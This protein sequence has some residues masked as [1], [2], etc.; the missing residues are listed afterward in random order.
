MRLDYFD[1]SFGAPRGV[2]ANTIDAPD[3]TRSVFVGGTF[4]ATRIRRFDEVQG[5]N[6]LRF[7]EDLELSTVASIDLGVT[8]FELDDDDAQLQ[9]TGT[10]SFRDT[11]A[12]SSTTYVS[13]SAGATARIRAGEAVGWSASCLLYT[14][15]SPRDQRGS[16]MPSSA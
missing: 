14:S 5:I 13:T 11:R 2:L 15:P 16:R 8:R 4:A 3:R 7:V 10:V 6:T 1:R 9:P 12:L